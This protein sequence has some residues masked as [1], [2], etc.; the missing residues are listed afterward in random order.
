[1]SSNIAET[2]AANAWVESYLNAREY[3]NVIHAF[4]SVSLVRVLGGGLLRICHLS[5]LR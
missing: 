2:T 1:M 3:D 5:I 4:T